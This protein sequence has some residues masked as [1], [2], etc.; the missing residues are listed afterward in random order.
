MRK[1]LLIDD[2][3]GNVRV[4][5]ISLKS[6]GYD[7]VT[8]FSGEEGLE[9]FDSESPDIVL[10]DLKMPGMNGLEVL[11]KVKENSPETEVI[12]ITGHG[13][14]DSA[15]EALQYGASDF[16]NKPIRDEGLSIALKRATEKIDIRYKL[17]QYTENLENLVKEATDEVW[18][19]SNFQI[20]LIRSSNDAI[21]A[22]DSDWKVVI[23]NPEAERIFGYPPSEVIGKMDITDLYPS[24]IKDILT[25]EMASEQHKKGLPWK[26]I[27]VLKRDG[28]KIPTRFSGSLLHEK[29]QVMGSVAFF[30]DLREIKRLETELVKSESLAAVGETVAGLAH[31]I[32]NILIGLE[33]GSYIVDVG[34]DRNDT[35]KLKTGWQ[36]IKRNIG[37][38]SDLVLD[39]LTYSKKREPEYQN[40]FPNEIVNDVCELVEERARENRIDIFTD[41]DPSIDEVTMDPRTIHR[42]LLNLVT[43]A[44]D[45]CLFDENTDKDWQIHVKTA[46]EKDHIIRFDVQDNGLGMDQKTVDQLF[47]TFFST[48]GGRGT[49]LGLLVTRK[50]IEEHRGTIDVKS[51]PGTGTTFTIRLPYEELETR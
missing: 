47:T 27:L 21:V 18:R 28:E 12:I 25:R 17:K 3:E 20:K 1:I 42:S 16:I 8:A 39:L 29:G 9:V 22:T 48:K 33:G 7:V 37:R 35:D 44:I 11:K 26:K 2:E 36:S 32:K 19:K 23:Y 24:E 40:C 30:Q 46:L 31:Y 34:F 50:L 14:I 10:T 6:D 49:G 51:R 38:I 43:N 45:A 41:F 13:D 15:I 4:L 5:S